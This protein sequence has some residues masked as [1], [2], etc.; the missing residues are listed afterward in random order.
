M[1]PT[2]TGPAT[3]DLVRCRHRRARAYAATDL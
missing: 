2:K 1:A 3:R